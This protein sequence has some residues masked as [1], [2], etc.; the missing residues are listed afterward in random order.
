MSK[1]ININASKSSSLKNSQKFYGNYLGIVIQN[2][3]PEKAGKVKVWIPH[4]SPSVYE[5]WDNSNEDKKFRF[6]GKNIDSD[7]SDIIDD[8]KNILPWSICAAPLNGS[9]SSGRYHANDDTAT[10]SDS[11]NKEDLLYKE[12]FVK[13]K[14]GLND[15]GIGEKPARK[16]E[17]EDLKI[18][19]A[20]VNAGDIPFENGNK[21]G[22]NYTPTSYS[23]SAKGSFGVPNVGSHVWVF[24][25]DGDPMRPVYF[26]V[27][28]GQE[29]WKSIYE[30][31]EE[32]GQDYPG[33]FENKNASLQ[34]QS[35]HNTTTYRNKYVINQK[36]GTLE[37]VN[38][39]N[40]EILKLTHYSGSFKEFSNYVNTEFAVN[41]D[42][43]LV[44]NDQ[45]LTVKGHKGV[46]VGE[47]LDFIINGD[48]Y[49]KVGN[50]NYNVFKEYKQLLDGVA[51]AKQLFDIKRATT[52]NTEAGFFKKTSANQQQVGTFGPCPVC[53]AGFRKNIWE[54]KYTFTSLTIPE[55]N[56]STNSYDFTNVT[57]N[58]DNL[59]SEL[60]LPSSNAAFLGDASCP[61]CGGSGLSPS[62]ENGTWSP[63]DKQELVINRLQTI[64]E[65]LIALEKQMGKGGNEIVTITKN[66]IENIG[67]VLNDFPS[68]RVDKQGKIDI[69]EIAVFDKGVA[70]IQK[71]R[72][73]FEYVHVDNLPGG[74]HVQNINNKWN[75]QVGSGGVS[76]KSIG[77]VDIGGSITNVT[78]QQTNIVSEEEVNIDA[79]T[80]NIAAEML[81]LRNKNKRQVVVDGNLGV[82]QNVVVGGSLHVEGELSVHHITAPVEI[83][84]T[85]PVVLYGKILGGKTI[86]NGSGTSVECEM[87]V[88]IYAHTHPFKNV[89]LKLMNDKD[90]VRKVGQAANQDERGSAIPVVHEK[91]DG[92]TIS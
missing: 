2:N 35:D 37:V 63:E 10:I 17:I 73:L 88:Q 70:A 3:D 50:L 14:Y 22:Y 45:F 68:I 24:F 32:N 8:L 55:Y 6:A 67:L 44:Q 85:E 66:K 43:K 34:E 52:I 16:Y 62:T 30:N 41:N 79:K 75:V 89:P 28:Y 80:V 39:D 61:V 18:S 51:D 31:S 15:D 25:D 33:T 91:K 78:G 23:N 57:S 48:N 72:P 64:N 59:S 56:D 82:N 26:A 92:E 49:H 90:D 7:L 20:F 76:I 54:N 77:G 87:A 38:T 83:Q 69:H 1:E 58:Y 11:N 5:K 46:Y 53:T 13:T 40:R 81:L 19:D 47:D 36:G 60:I 74:T 9:N 27:S 84:E 4:I 12:D 86:T 71:E 29:D 42:Q 21:Y 65:D